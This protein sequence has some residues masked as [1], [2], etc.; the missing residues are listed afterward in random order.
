MALTKAHNRMI[1]GAAVNVKDF[2]AVGDGVTDDTAAIQAAI[3]SITSGTIFV[4]KGTYKITSNIFLGGRKSLQ[5]EDKYLSNF[6]FDI[7]AGSGNANTYVF[8]LGTN[9]Y[10]VAATAWEGHIADMGFK[11]SDN[12]DFQRALFVISCGI[13]EI[14]NCIWDM[15]NNIATGFAQGGPIES[16][17]NVAWATGGIH[18]QLKLV[19]CIAR[20]NHGF[21]ASEG[22]GLSLF[23]NAEMVRCR[24]FG[25][26]DDVFA[27]HECTRARI[28]DCVGFAITGRILNDACDDFAAVGN[29]IT[30]ISDP[31]TGTW[32]TGS[33]CESLISS[34]L[35]TTPACKK[36]IYRDN[37]FIS[38]PG[39]KV[40]YYIRIQHAQ[41]SVSIIDNQIVNES[42]DPTNGLAI[43]IEATQPPAGASWTGEV[44][45]PDY[46]NGGFIR[47]RNVVIRGNKDI[48]PYQARSLTQA[49][50]V[51]NLLGPFIIEDNILND[52][53]VYTTGNVRFGKTNI[54]ISPTGLQNLGPSP[55][56]DADRMTYTFSSFA[57]TSPTVIPPINVT[58]R[59]DRDSRIV[60]C[61]TA[62]NVNGSSGHSLYVRILVNG[63]QIIQY[64]FG[65]GSALQN[66]QSFRTQAGFEVSTGDIITV[67][68]FDSGNAIPISGNVTVLL[69]PL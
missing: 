3:D 66:L 38:P 17:N 11:A 16:G 60:G 69:Q 10:G 12:A 14:R 31:H 68:I 34:S 51:A 35:T 29:T 47:P 67:T 25:C 43:S 30:K 61:N 6:L 21:G 55:C 42:T 52:Y 36:A 41:E 27:M 44:G 40:G 13:S 37:I 20:L 23:D 2:G 8:V 48:G 32:H 65:I 45:N 54:A 1:E 7:A 64:S 46:S 57:T 4:P 24:V 5:G 28:I 58:S 59:V 39:A 49:G 15:T 26:A 56:V 18:T 19:D 62:W 9:S 33:F 22:F 50:T 53:V 63:V